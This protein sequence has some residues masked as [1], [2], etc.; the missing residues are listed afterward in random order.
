[1][2]NPGEIVNQRYQLQ[3][4][5]GRNAGRQTWLAKDTAAEDNLVVVKLLAFGGDVE[6]VDLKL[7]EREAQ[8]LQQ[9]NHNCIPQY[10]DYFAIG[11]R[12]LWFGLVQQY[13]PGNSLRELLDKGKRF[14]V[15]E[16]EQIARE[17]LDILLYLHGYNPPL[18][19]RDIKPSNLMMGEDGHIHLVDFGAVQD[20]A[21][22]EGATFTVVGTYGYAPMEQFGGKAV[23][24]SDLYSLGATIVHL[25]TRTPPGDL[26]TEN[27]RLQF[28]DRVSL[29]PPFAKWLDTMLHPAVERRY[30]N[31]QEA[32]QG[33][34]YELVKEPSQDN[35]SLAVRQRIKVLNDTD[36][37]DI[38]ITKRG[39]EFATK[40]LSN[41]T[42]AILLFLASCFLVVVLPGKSGLV[43]LLICAI[44]FYPYLDYLYSKTRITASQQKL[45]IENKFWFKTTSQIVKTDLIQDVSINYQALENRVRDPRTS[46]RWQDSISMTVKQPESNR[47][48]QQVSFAK[49]LNEEEAIFLANK[50]RDWLQRS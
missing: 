45:N 28:Q 42:V 16:V 8:T 32:L 25:L 40:D 19:H 5:L 21:A 44:A 46:S 26:P 4:K 1:M 48:Y 2:L 24:A 50:I 27:L 35:V 17:V 12:N 23:P 36:Y 37:L 3:S 22:T 11:D 47:K 20:R 43:I 29:N 14:S 13:I 38:L 39:F 18:L 33:L 15:S 34:D 49:G 41:A 10:L 6:W 31:A 7:F 9:L 30:S